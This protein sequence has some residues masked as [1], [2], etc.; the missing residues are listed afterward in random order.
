MKKHIVLHIVSGIL[1]AVLLM[2][3]F[4]LKN[5]IQLLE[6]QLAESNVSNDLSYE[7][8]LELKQEIKTL[9]DQVADYENQLTLNDNRIAML[10]EDMEWDAYYERMG[11]LYTSNKLTYSR[12]LIEFLAKAYEDEKDYFKF[13]GA[14]DQAMYVRPS[15]YLPV[16]G[17][18]LMEQLEY[19]ADALSKYTFSGQII[20]VEGIEVIDG[21]KIANIDLRDPEGYEG[22]FIRNFL[23]GSTGGIMTA[24]RLIETFLQ[25]ETELDDWVDGIRFY[26]EGERGWISDHDPSICRYT[27]FRDG[28]SVEDE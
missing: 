10:I 7:E 5:T 17:E 28:T 23:Q 6:G 26:Y 15:Y 12:R 18:S 14:D 20:V 24:D 22:A 1:I 9:N 3:G 16:Q 4:S 19:M 25:R 27:Y 13:Y 8:N 21:K 2:I 11:N